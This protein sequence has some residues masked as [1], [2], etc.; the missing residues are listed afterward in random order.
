MDV[1]C[2]AHIVQNL[3]SH[4]GGQGKN[5]SS[6]QKERAIEREWV[7]RQSKIES[8]APLTQRHRKLFLNIWIMLVVYMYYG[9]FLLLL[10]QIGQIENVLNTRKHLMEVKVRERERRTH[11]QWYSRWFDRFIFSF[12]FFYF[13]QSVFVRLNLFATA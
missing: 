9:F 4:N 13:S 3:W 7:E 11:T 6:T 5:Q 1:L 2:G 8:N 12:R 10:L